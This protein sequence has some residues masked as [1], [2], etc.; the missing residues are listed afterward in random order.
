MKNEN[1]NKKIIIRCTHGQLEV[2]W[3]EQEQAKVTTKE[4]PHGAH[5]AAWSTHGRMEHI[6]EN[7]LQPQRKKMPKMVA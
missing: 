6:F 7:Y 3:P 5:M 2:T 4:W 1:L